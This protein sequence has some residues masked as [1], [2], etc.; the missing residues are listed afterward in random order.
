MA[1]RARIVAGTEVFYDDANQETVSS[2]AAFGF[3]EEFVGAGHTAGF[4]AMG[5]PTAG[6]AW[7]KKIVGSGPPTAA[8]VTNAAGGQA[9]FALAATSEAEEAALTWNDSLSLDLTKRALIEYRAALAVPP[10]A[11]NTSAFI[12]VAQAWTSGGALSSP[13][14]LGFGWS[15]SNGL[16]LY[17]KDGVNTYAVNAALI[18]SPGTQ[19]TSDTNFHIFGID[20]SNTADVAFMVDGNRVNAVGSVTWGTTS[21][22]SLMQAYMSVAKASGT[23]LATLTVDKLDI[24]ANRV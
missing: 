23:G 4:P 11:A 16:V 19:V 12:G 20:V 13:R 1:T 10:S 15:A 6:Y 14:Y 7:V 5:S 21:A 24:Y 18:A 17:S 9:Q 22:N 8:L 3:S 2:N